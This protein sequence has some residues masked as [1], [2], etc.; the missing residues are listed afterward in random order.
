MSFLNNGG[1]KFYQYYNVDIFVD[2]SN[3]IKIINKVLNS[4]NEFL[5]ITRPRRFGKTLTISML[6]SYYSKGSNSKEIFDN[7]EIS[8][9]PEYL[10]HLNKHNVIW[11]DMSALY[12]RHKEN[13]INEF[14]SKLMD[15]LKEAYPGILTLKENTIADS[16][17]KINKVKGERFI[18]LIDEWDVIFREMPN[19]NL[20]D[21]YIMLLRDLFKSS[22]VSEC[23]DLVYMTGILPIKRYNTES[24]LNMFKEYNMLNPRNLGEYIG[25]SEDEVKKLCEKYSVDF[26]MMKNWYDGYHLGNFEIYNPESVVE[27]I[28]SKEFRDYWTST[29]ALESITNYM[30][31]DNGELKETIALMLTG[32]KVKLDATLFDN[33]LTEINSKDAALTVLIHLGYLA[34]DA[35]SSSCYIPNYEIKKEFEK[36]IKS[37]KW[38]SLCNPILNSKKLY[39]ETLNGNIE[40][41]NKI[42]DENH[43]NLVSINNKNNEGVLSVIC[44]IS[45]YD[46]LNYYFIRNED[47]SSA[48]RAD[49]TFTPKDKEHIPMIIELKIDKEPKNAI[50]QIKEKKYINV[51]NG[52]KGKVLLVG[53]SYDSKTLKHNSMIEY[54]DIK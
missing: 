6:N 28:N 53:I 54:I 3:I 52:Y 20:C 50:D 35:K 47:S 26:K 2:K 10:K 18:F 49:L 32:E 15:E 31:Y 48:G 19:S 27:A 44:K 14:K 40:C 45:Y 11:V 1:N 25:F 37:L 12:T 46:A 8:K 16:I 41:I 9:D 22:D 36:G 17:I 51:F 33:D 23:L 21:E 4:S 34:F 43:Q 38:N 24:A 5:C 7:L 42:L 13:F 30:N 29:G 39:E